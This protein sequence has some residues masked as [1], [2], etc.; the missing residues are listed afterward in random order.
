M[1]AAVTNE[2][3]SDSG[4]K[5]RHLGSSLR[6]DLADLDHYRIKGRPWGLGKTQIWGGYPL[7]EGIARHINATAIKA[8]YK[9]N[10]T[11]LDLS[12]QGHPQ[13]DSERENVGVSWI[14]ESTVAVARRPGLLSSCTSLPSGFP[15]ISRHFC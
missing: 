5:V 2:I 14:V 3:T 11:P 4:S 1:P 10:Q 13:S 7:T 6:N 15:G 12:D 8:K 9:A